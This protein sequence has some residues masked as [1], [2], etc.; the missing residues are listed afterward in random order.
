MIDKNKIIQ[1]LTAMIIMGRIDSDNIIPMK[2]IKPNPSNRVES[3]KKSKKLNIL[4]IFFVCFTS[5][6]IISSNHS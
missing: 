3:I 5:F 1:R 2:S 6:S 4:T